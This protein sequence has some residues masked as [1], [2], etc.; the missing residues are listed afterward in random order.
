MDTATIERLPR[1]VW[2]VPAILLAVAVARLPY[3]YYTLTRIVACSAAI[4]I[5]VAS[6]RKGEAAGEAWA[7]VFC[8]LA[9]LL[10]PIVPIH[11]KRETWFFLDFGTAVIFVA[12]LVMV[13]ARANAVKC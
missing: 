3:G 4:V 8:V 5:A 9:I 1:L 11:F 2:I 6:H 10:N 7:A 13:R 12:H